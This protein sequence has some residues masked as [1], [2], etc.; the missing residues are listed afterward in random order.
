MCKYHTYTIKTPLTTISINISKSILQQLKKN[1][2]VCVL[3]LCTKKYI[4]VNE[5][6]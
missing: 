3:I 1:I 2:H 6:N 5:M 4:N